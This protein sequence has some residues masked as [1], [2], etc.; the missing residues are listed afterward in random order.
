MWGARSEARTGLSSC[1]FL[2]GLTLVGVVKAMLSGEAAEV[3]MEEFIPLL[4]LS[5]VTGLWVTGDSG[6]QSVCCVA[7]L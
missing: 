5:S 2:G 3:Q 6:S 1:L 7:G 4:L